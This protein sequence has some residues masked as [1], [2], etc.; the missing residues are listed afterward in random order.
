[1]TSIIQAMNSRGV[2]FATDSAVSWKD[3]HAR[4]S[5]QKLFSLPGRQ[6]IA[7]MVMGSG[8]FA[9]TGLS[10]DRIFHKYN[11]QYREKYG[12]ELELDTVRDYE[13]DFIDFLD[14]LYD[15]QVNDDALARDI[16]FHWDSR[17][18]NFASI[19]S[20]ESSVPDD[21]EDDQSIPTVER[22]SFYSVGRLI[23][24]W[25][26]NSWFHT[27]E[28]YSDID[29]QYRT[30]QVESHHLGTIKKAAEWVMQESYDKPGSSINTWD[31]L[32]S[33]LD[34]ETKSEADSLLDRLIVVIT[35]WLA[36][37]GNNHSWKEGSSKAEV[38]FG[39]FGRNDE[40][41]ITTH[42]VTG[43]RVKGLGNFDGLLK[44]R[45]IVDPTYF[46]GPVYDS[47]EGEWRCFAYLQAFAQNEFIMRVTA[48]QDLSLKHDI[49]SK[50]RDSLEHWISNTLSRDIAEVDGVGKVT[51]KSI[52]DHLEGKEHHKGFSD[53]M[54]DYIADV[55][56]NTK[57][58]FR[59]A[60]DR[61]SPP[62]LADLTMDLIEVQAKMHNIVNPQST[63][64]LPVDVCYLSK[65]NGFIWHRR[66][67]VPDRSINPRLD[68]MK[69]DGS[70][71]D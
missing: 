53:Y 69:W 9:P 17:R 45:N 3:G 4:P 25:E 56:N 49:R 2:A 41:P 67:N 20:A 54:H 1:M 37:W 5:A 28:S 24:D 68:Y 60:I 70:Q 16:Y 38:V 35:R 58:N 22:S 26:E 14:S 32:Y 31:S 12:A 51:V 52:I 34:E 42:I 71:L 47:E 21:M 29:H 33:E 27:E 46:A 11:I 6:P 44:E 7:F 39:G 61:L 64:N 18:A 48:G 36:S 66:K 63:V 50:F 8:T 40:F 10:W 23:D 57:Q 30:R 43:S 15:P 59:V 55:G 13:K 65:E 62:E 19:S